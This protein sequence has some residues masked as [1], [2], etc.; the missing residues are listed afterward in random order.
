M[1]APLL[2]SILSLTAPPPT[3]L[4]R[5]AAIASALL[6]TLAP[7]LPAYAAGE[8]RSRLLS[9][10]QSGGDVEAALAAL[11]PLDPS[12]GKAATSTVLGGEWRLLWSAKTEAFRSLAL[13][14]LARARQRVAGGHE[15]APPHSVA[16][17]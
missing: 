17:R 3:E 9:A 10:I 5:R 2:S 12:R 4:G 6:T 8:E 15:R 1:L 14:E 13:I 11:L 7:R 16:Q